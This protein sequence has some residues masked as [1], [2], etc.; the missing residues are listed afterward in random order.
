MK[1]V[2]IGTYPP[3]QCGIGTFTNNL[4]NSMTR[5]PKVKEKKHTGIVVAMNGEDKEHG[6]PE[7]VEF[8]IKPE[9]KSY[10]QAAKDINKCGADICI[11]QHEFG[12]F[13]G[14]DG[15]YV[16][17][18]L[19]RLKIPVIVTF[20]T[21]LNKP[22]YNRKLIVKEICKMAHK[23]VV[24]SNKAV[25]FL[26]SVYKVPKQKISMIEHGVPNIQ[27]NHKQ[28][29]Q[30]LK[31]EN[32]KVILTFGFVSKNKGIET[33]IK[34][35]PDVVKKH[36]ETLYII[37]GKTHPN[38]LKSSGEEYRDYLE[39]LTK[40]LGLEN[41]VLFLNK[42][43]DQQELF[44]YLYAAD[45]YVSPY[46]NVAQI[47]SGTLSYAIGAGLASISTPYW[48][49]EELLANGR[50]KLFNFKNSKE[51]S[52]IFLEILD[53]PEIL[54]NLREKAKEYGKKIMWPKIGGK[55]IL[56]AEEV[57]FHKPDMQAQK[58]Q[59]PDPLK[60]QAFSLDHIKTLTDGTG[61]CKNAKFAIPKLSDG[62]CTDDNS[63]A[64][65]M[66]L[67]A[68]KKSKDPDALKLAS[69]Y[70]SFIHYMQ[71]DDGS[72]RNFLSFN[73]FFSDEKVSEDAFGRTI[74]ALGYLLKNPPND[75]FYQ[76]AKLMFFKA[77][78]CFEKLKSPRGIANTIMGLSHYLKSNMFDEA[79]Q[80]S[81]KTLA[82]K[83]LG[84]YEK[85][86]SLYWK[87]FEPT[88]TYDNGI[89]PLALLHSAELLN[90]N[91]ITKAAIK[92]MHFLTKLTFSKG[93][94]SPIGNK[95]WYNKFD[96]KSSFAQQPLD[97]MVMVLMY[98]QAF[99]LTK[100]ND[101]LNKLYVSF[102][103]FHGENDLRTSLFDSETKGCCDRIESYGINRDQ[104]AESS[105]S[106]LVSHIAVCEEFNIGL[107]I[108]SMPKVQETHYS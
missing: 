82:F 40:D 33:T 16:L 32:K 101:Y 70:L 75:A 66:V 39:S 50:G 51:L 76:I 80:L 25:D 61:I 65:L 12:I 41:N 90:N 10:I 11:L 85:N 56:L 5:S 20:H 42:Y 91:N 58:E 67:M 8:T 19:H 2:Y 48:H 30:E 87:W 17:P 62:Y 95:K 105:I 97:A 60:L 14:N 77:A 13:D 38:I 6:Y 74:W 29:K 69:K 83:L 35:L 78:P 22:S 3:R 36:P 89:L 107:S 92:S 106:Y 104:G 102:M 27:F 96:V 21:V 73:R 72:F 86:S 59:I 94:L 37:L 24:M 108:V 31:L 100:N 81:L 43:T 45:I 18:L 4:L 93:Y 1:F 26:S 49:A 55:Y 46:L 64:L 84:H 28:V 98:Q 23:V 63:R 71:N 47:T 9:L 53:K 79:M 103:W 15:I 34:A 68:H 7:E 88:L 57:L 54:K 52:N 99:K 44:K